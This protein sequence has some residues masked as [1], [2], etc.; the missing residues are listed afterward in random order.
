MNKDDLDLKTEYKACVSGKIISIFG[1][2]EE[3][4]LLVTL[5]DGKKKGVTVPIEKLEKQ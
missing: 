5:S 3:V 1:Y 4:M 2:S